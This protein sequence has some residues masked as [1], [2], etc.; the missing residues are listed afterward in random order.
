MA[1]LFSFPPVEFSS[2]PS[3]D[4]FSKTDK[5]SLR[6]F[7]A[8]E[9]AESCRNPLFFGFFFDGTNNN[10]MANE[11][12]KS[13]SNVAR[14]YD[15]FPGQSVK[16]VLPDA[17]NWSTTPGQFKHFFRVYA[18]GVGTEFEGVGNIGNGLWGKAAGRGGESRIIWALAQAINNVHRYF[19]DAP[20]LSPDEIRKLIGRVGL[21]SS[22]LRHMQ[23]PAD[24][25]RDKDKK[26]EKDAHARL[27]FERHLRKL[28]DAVR[29]HWIKKSTCQPEK[30][31]PGIV[32]GIHLSIFGFSRGAT[33]ARAFTNW[34][35]ALCALDAHLCGAPGKYSLGG[36]PV[37]FD[38]LGIFDTVA[39]VGLGNTAGNAWI[40]RMLDGHATWA[41]SEYSL[42]IP[43][44]I[45]C[46]HLVAAHEIRRS[47]PVDSVAVG[48]T[49]PANC[50]EVVFPGVHSDVG[51]GYMPTEQGRG[52][53]ADGAD[54]MAR[55]PLIY[56]YREATL[57][58]VPLKLDIASAAVKEKFRVKKQ[59]VDAMTAYLS[60]CKVKTGSL[61]AIM[62]EQTKLYINWHRNRLPGTSLPL[63]ATASFK[64]ATPF[65]QNDLHSANLEFA[66]EVKAFEQWRKEKGANF[67][68]RAQQPGF[69]NDYENEWEEISS[70][71]DKEKSVQ[72]E[73]AHFFDEYVHDSRAWFKLIG[74]DNEADLREELNKKLARRKYVRDYN[75]RLS[76]AGSSLRLGRVQQA[77]VSDG[78]TKEERAAVD[79]FERTG[80]IPRM[81]N[82]GR[83]M[84]TGMRAGY[85]RYR[86]VYAGG[87]K[88][89]IS[90]RTERETE[91][92]VLA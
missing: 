79:E 59:V 28:H 72:P 44:G 16:G 71:W 20:L 42:R 60:A 86:K 9:M 73:V 48:G 70:W 23:P 8:R 65:D 57:A 31:N 63:D 56:M 68:P 14:L 33:Q 24:T 85:L 91:Q 74:A 7:A 88:I 22:S 11:P 58:G 61:T 19:L 81:V 36:F 25:K 13:Q 2:S 83:E 26:E 3:L 17:K 52:V 32:T 78:L 50:K 54:M 53:D 34:L 21:N 84:F 43:E 6:G 69:D 30:K 82:S 47:F 92:A 27:E 1:T 76:P 51:C 37:H 40:A 10:Y 87:D 90:Q 77:P 66:E 12:T 75:S 39:S 80:K 45:K 29:P 18:P 41:D 4:I 62:R 55:I 35:K 46:V 64:R 49:L 89:L 15:T 67:K 38:F 5:D